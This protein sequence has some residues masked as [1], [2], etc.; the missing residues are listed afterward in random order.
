MKARNT[1]W[2]KFW[3]YKMEQG[4]YKLGQ[5]EIANWG[6]GITKSGKIGLHSGAAFWITKRGKGLPSRG[7]I[8]YWD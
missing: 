5:D 7:E 2:N 3:D 8:T 1:K 6:K 4:D